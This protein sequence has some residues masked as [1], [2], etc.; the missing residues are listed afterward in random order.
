MCPDPNPNTRLGLGIRLDFDHHNRYCLEPSHHRGLHR[1]PVK[2]QDH[3][4]YRH[5]CPHSKQSYPDRHKHHRRQRYQIHN[6][7]CHPDQDYCPH[8]LRASNTNQQNYRDYPIHPGQHRRTKLSTFHSNH[9]KYLQPMFHHRY[10]HS[11]GCLKSN[12]HPRHCCYLPNRGEHRKLPLKNQDFPT[13]HHPNRC[14]QS[15]V[16][17]NIHRSHREHFVRY[18]LRHNLPVKYQVPDSNNSVPDHHNL[19]PSLQMEH[20]KIP[21]HYQHQ[22]RHYQYHHNTS[23]CIHKS[24]HH[25]LRQGYNYMQFHLCIRR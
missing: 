5:L 6:K 9:L 21:V 24:H 19:S 10:R 16:R 1:I 15:G 2:F 14:K 12:Y 8:T 13:R 20:H 18:K 7:R 22:I 17:Y 25:C 4:T 3:Q 11:H 23:Q